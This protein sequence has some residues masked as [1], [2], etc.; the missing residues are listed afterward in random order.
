MCICNFRLVE[1]EGQCQRDERREEITHRKEGKQE[2]VTS[3]N[4]DAKEK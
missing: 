3:L 2:E 1:L 4:E